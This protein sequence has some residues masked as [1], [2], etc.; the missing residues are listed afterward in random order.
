MIIYAATYGQT[1]YVV[2]HGDK[3]ADIVIH[4]DTWTYI[5]ICSDIWADSNTW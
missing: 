3:L 5:V 2:I 1:L 4:G